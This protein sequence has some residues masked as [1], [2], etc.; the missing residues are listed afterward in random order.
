MKHPWLT[1]TGLC[2]IVLAIVMVCVIF[3]SYT[4]MLRS[5]N[6]VHKG[7][8]LMIMACEN[9]LDQIPGLV[10][11]AKGDDA[12]PVRSR[13]HDTIEQIRTLLDQFRTSDTPLDPDLVRIFEQ[14]QSRLAKDLDALARAIGTAHPR[15]QE[16]ADRY[17]E[18]IY[19][20]RRYNKEAVYFDNRKKVFPGMFTSE[21]FNLGSLQFPKIDLTCFDPWGLK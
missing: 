13:I 2:A 20:A 19:A 12:A 8:E 11:L 3:G 9:Q 6:R 17:L 10:A 18:T 14:A 16:T 15:V 7:K 1:F 4:S 21:W 5:K